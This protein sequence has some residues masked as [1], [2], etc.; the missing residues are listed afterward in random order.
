MRYAPEKV[1]GSNEDLVPCCYSH[2]ECLDALRPLIYIDTFLPASPSPYSA[3][4]SLI[5]NSFELV[6]LFILFLR[7]FSFSDASAWTSCH[8]L[9]FLRTS[10][11]QRKLSQLPQNQPSVRMESCSLSRKKYSKSS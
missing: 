11:E 6:I 5:R 10:M 2:T 4:S 9:F 8:L 7:I 3:S 1:L